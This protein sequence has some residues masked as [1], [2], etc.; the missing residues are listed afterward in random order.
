MNTDARPV[1]NRVYR[2]HHFDSRRWDAVRFRLDDIVI[3]TSYKAGT[4][5]TQRIV[6]LLILGPQKLSESLMTLSPWVDM[7]VVPIGDVV[8]HIDAQ[9]HR[10]FL[11]T[12]LPLDAL[13]W[14]DAIKYVYVGR[15]GRDVMMSW[16]NHWHSFTDEGIAFLNSGDLVGDPIPKCPDDVREFFDGWVHRASFPW[17]QDGWPMWSH[18]YHAQSFWNFRHL[19]NIHFVHYADLKAD[20]EGEM[21]RIARFLDIDVSQSTWPAIVERASFEAMKREAIEDEMPGGPSFF[22]NGVR[23][24]FFKGTNGRWRDVLTR[25]DLAEY[26]KA[27][28][29]ALTPDCAAWLERGRQAGDPK[30]V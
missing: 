27:V 14:N 6:S 16:F 30:S 28:E 15:D 7:R 9:Q 10:R 18:L 24:F 1:R 20:R 3:A 4:T 23:D 8:A 26:D 19:P 29:R 12:H 5:W 21:R 22:K 13:P 17:E 25:E 11:K 2:N